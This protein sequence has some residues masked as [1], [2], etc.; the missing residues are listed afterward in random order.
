PYALAALEP[1]LA[2]ALHAH[3]E[4]ARVPA[5]EGG[6][7]RLSHPGEIVDVSGLHS[8]RGGERGQ[9][10]GEGRLVDV[11]SDTQDEVTNRSRPR[12]GRFGKH[13]ADLPLSH[14]D[15]IRPSY[16]RGQLSECPERIDDGHRSHEGELGRLAWR[17]GRSKD[18]GHEQA[19]PVL[20]EPWAAGARRSRPGP[21]CLRG[22]RSPC[23]PFLFPCRDGRARR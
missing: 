22:T 20:V 18:D 9:R 21:A 3:G 19:L 7:H 4:K 6:Q 12:G 13:P 17:Y 2:E 5:I 10:L 15:V 1:R 23:V 8:Y 11:Q 16:G 14:H